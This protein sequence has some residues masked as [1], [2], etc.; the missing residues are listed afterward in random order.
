MAT[1]GQYGR[2]QQLIL[3]PYQERVVAVL[4]RKEGL[5]SSHSILVPEEAVSAMTDREVRLKISREQVD[6]L[7]EYRPEIGLVVEGGT[8]RVDDGLL[9]VRGSEGIEV[10]RPSTG[11]HLRRFESQVIGS[12]PEHVAL[13]VRAGQQV[14]CQDGLAGHV[15]LIL[16][17]PDGRV[18]GLVMH[19]GHLPGPDLIVP[20]AW[21]QEVD[22][23]DVQ[24]SVD[25]H[26]LQSLPEYNPDD[27]LT[28]DVKNAL[29]ADDILRGI[30]YYEIDAT[31]QDG[32]VRLRGH[33]ATEM[34]KS[35][36]EEAAR[37]VAGELGIEN[38]LV[39]DEDLVVRVAQALGRDERIRM[40]QVCVGA[41]HGVITLNG[42]VATASLRV[43]AEGVA[44][45]V[46]QVRAVV[47]A[48]QAPS[49]HIDPEEQ[50][51][52]QPPIGQEVYATDALLGS[53]E[54]VIISPDNRRVTSFV[55]HGSLP[56]LLDAHER[57]MAYEIPQQERRVVVPIRAVRYVTE[58]SVW[59]GVS[60]LEA[61]RYR[62]FDS[63]DFASPP[64][65]WQAPYPY[66]WDDVVFPRVKAD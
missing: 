62:D 30:D 32:I 17:E 58:S 19:A 54:R 53:I 5:L 39:V 47:N 34:N 18:K 23:N 48:I 27:A 10:Y 31:V 49:L 46:P 7:P 63:A 24:L 4:V 6:A 9:A 35:R 29:W 14:F 13:Q 2:L 8:Y 38:H 56:D 52:L 42:R 3:D 60:S 25:K 41:R 20:A 36:A 40:E 61:A 16:L 28:A 21:V 22:P 44:A 57:R 66:R 11:Q 1:D 33:V 43:V 15:S 55:A 50:R 26:A 65:A 45:S 37:S 12:E 59:L 51:A 64:E